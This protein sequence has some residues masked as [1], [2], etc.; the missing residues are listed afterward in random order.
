MCAGAIV[1]ARIATVV[2]GAS[3]RAAGACGSAFEICGKKVMNHKTSVVSGV[4]AGQCQ[5]L[6]TEFFTLVRDTD[7]GGMV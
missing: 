1:N 6:L 2:Y 3:D 5:Q 4:M 7:S